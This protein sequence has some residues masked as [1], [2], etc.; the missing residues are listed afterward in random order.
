[1]RLNR[2]AMDRITPFSGSIDHLSLGGDRQVLNSLMKRCKSLSP[3][4]DR[5]LPGRVTVD[6][7]N[8]GALVSGTRELWL[9]RAYRAP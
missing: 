1:M 8:T 2:D 3:L 5:V 9:W 7:P 6:R 4:Q